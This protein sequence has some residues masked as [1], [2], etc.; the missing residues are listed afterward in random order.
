MITLLGVITTNHS[1]QHIPK[2]ATIVRHKKRVLGVV[3]AYALLEN[4]SN[5]RV[6]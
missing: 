2:K 5:E 6:L 4:I 3:V 1:E